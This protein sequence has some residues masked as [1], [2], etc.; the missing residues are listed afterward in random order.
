MAETNGYYDFW[1]NSQKGIISNWMDLT[2][3]FQKMIFG[4]AVSQ[5]GKT[6]SVQDIFN[7]Y[8]SWIRT[9]GKFFDGMMK[10]YP[11]GVG[12]DTF[13]KLFSGAD[14]YMKLFNFWKPMYEAWS[15]RG[16]S[17]EAY[18]DLFDPSKYK[19]II[20]K[21][22]GFGEPATM[23]EFYSQ[24]SKLVETWGSSVQNYVKPW[25][26]ALQKNLGAFP[27]IMAG[28]PE[29]NLNMFHNVY[30]AFQMTSGKAFKMPQVGKDKEKVELLMTCFDKY[31][32]YIAKNTE[33]QY[34]MYVTGQNAMEKVV[35]AIGEKIKKG[36]QVKHYDEFF[37]LWTDI[38]EDEYYEL[39][40]TERF[41]KVQGRL[42][43]AA[44]DARAHI[45][46]LMEL[47]LDDY[48]VVLRSEINDLYKSFYEL[49]KKVRGL[50]K[51]LKAVSTKEV[52][53]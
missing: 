24:A 4:S 27:E 35:K 36:D 48:P 52:T 26:D 41:S 18:K 31:S 28:T 14:A 10:D 20:D 6:E 32:E 37:K 21:V 45:Q 23:T 46:K 53:Q 33:F 38:N 16:F 49:K 2:K 50:E 15:Q 34:E 5:E 22:F 43:Q 29:V 25:A 8:N 17:P 44:M 40:K 7:F 19:E 11:T 1:L 42:L 30:N 51:Q 47:Y 3:N 12:K 9:V 13:S 39:F